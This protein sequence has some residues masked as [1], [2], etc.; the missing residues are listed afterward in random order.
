MHEPLDPHLPNSE[1]L[2]SNMFRDVPAWAISMGVH[3]VILLILGS[4]THVVLLDD[5]RTALTSTMDEDINQEEFKFDV[6]VTDQLGNESDLNKLSPSQA[7]AQNKGDAPDTELDQQLEEDNFTVEIPI[8]QALQQPAEANLTEV[9]D[10]AGETDHPGG[11][12]GAMDRITFELLASLKEKP[13]FALWMFDAS[14]SL[15]ARREAIANRF[16][17]VYKQLNTVNKGRFGALKTG[18]VSYGKSV[19]F[20]TPAPV[21]D[22][23]DVVK[24]VRDIKPDTSG[25]EYVFSALEVAMNKWIGLRTKQRRNMMVIIVTD[26]R[27]D[28]IEKLESVIQFAKRYGIRCYCVGNGASFGKQKGPVE[29]TFPDGY[30]ETYYN[31]ADMGPES[32]FPERLQLAFWGNAQRSR[33]LEWVSSGYGPYALTRLCGETGGL[34]LVSEPPLGGAQVEYS[35]MR[36]YAPDYRPIRMLESDVKRSPAKMA[37]VAAATSSGASNIPTPTLAF[38]ADTDTVLRQELTEAQKPLAV[39]DYRLNQILTQLQLGEKARASLTEPRWRASF[40]LAM[41]RALAMRARAYGYNYVLA[42]MK[43]N[44]KSFETK[45]NNQWRLVPSK[46]ITAGP[47]VKKLA[48]KAEE[49]LKR[50]VDDHEGTPWAM[51]AANELSQPLGWE[52]KEAKIVIPKGMNGNGNEDNPRLLLAEEEQRRRQMQQQQKRRQ[53]PKL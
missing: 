51:L 47:N 19:N 39:L 18:V 52:W 25:Q 30:K 41:G 43:A 33:K 36:N 31:I 8:T 23:E 45:G 17:N 38:R 10:I 4:F 21:D 48:K 11:V 20:I 5:P 29:Y 24:A 40:D 7:M 15:N 49:Y 14:Q 26:E 3:V 34:Y 16:E 44:P 28:D 2:R 27:G 37:L 6:T 12:E 42:E 53:P 13:T 50:V 9:V 22:V 32:A 35:V 46:E 1:S